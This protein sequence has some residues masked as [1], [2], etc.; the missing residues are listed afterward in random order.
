MRKSWGRPESRVNQIGTV[1]V[2]FPGLLL[3]LLLF[4]GV[5]PITASAGVLFGV[6]AVCGAVGGG[7]NLIGR[8]PVVIGAL[9][10]LAIAVGGFGAVVGWLHIRPSAFWFEIALVY[11]AGTLPG[12]GL[13]R[14]LQPLVTRQD[15]PA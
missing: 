10:G 6:T 4:L 11:F 13:Q 7:I 5:I 9:V 8:G 15:G 2:I 12:F 14:A 1:L 3:A